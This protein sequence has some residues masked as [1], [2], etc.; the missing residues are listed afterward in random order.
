MAKHIRLRSQLAV[1]LPLTLAVAICLTLLPFFSLALDE[2]TYSDIFEKL[3]L[4]QNDDIALLVASQTQVIIGYL[5]NK[6][7]LDTAFFSTQAVMHME[8]VRALFNQCKVVLTVAAVVTTFLSLW[9]VIKGTLHMALLSFIYAGLSVLL[10]L[11]ILAIGSV[12]AFDTLFVVFHQIFF[13]NELWL[14]S[15]EDTLVQLLP[16]AFFVEFTKLWLITTAFV[17][18]LMCTISYLFLKWGREQE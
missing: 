9:L 1:V 5:S 3:G 8:D 15:P 16:T 7:P 13:R 14:F 6:N 2:Q 12:V 17:S 11:V 4:Y 18:F 10:L